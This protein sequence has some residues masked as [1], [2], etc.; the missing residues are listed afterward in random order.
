M[1]PWFPL[2]PSHSL[3]VWHGEHVHP[4]SDS[5]TCA[6]ASCLCCWKPLPSTVAGASLGR[7]VLGVGSKWG[8]DN[9]SIPQSWMCVG[10]RPQWTDAIVYF[11]LSSHKFVAIWAEKWEDHEKPWR[12]GGSLFSE[13]S[14]WLKNMAL[15]L[16]TV[17]I[18]TH[19]YIILYIIYIYV[20]THAHTYI[21]I[22]MWCN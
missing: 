6:G 9:L 2:K 21:Y 18:C 22:K 20:Y 7:W 11:C 19:T 13:K 10:Q 4:S 8:W 3:R 17:C 14:T 12:F 16:F 5:F 15:S 1:N